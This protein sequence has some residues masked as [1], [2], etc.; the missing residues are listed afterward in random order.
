MRGSNERQAGMLL[1]VTTKSLIPAE[2]PIRHIREGN[3]PDVV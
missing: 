1:D 3:I 2:H